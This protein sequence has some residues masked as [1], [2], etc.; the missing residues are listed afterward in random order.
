MEKF[1]TSNGILMVHSKEYNWKLGKGKGIEG[2]LM[3]D[4]VA[5]GRD[6]TSIIYMPER[7]EIAFN[8]D[9]S[10]E[11]ESPSIRFFAESLEYAESLAHN[12]IKYNKWNLEDTIYD[13][14]VEAPNL[15]CV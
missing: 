9:F 6:Y 11:S 7:K 3:L 10:A 15:A 4:L 8:G 14:K 13:V 5:W 12:Y 2:W 1:T